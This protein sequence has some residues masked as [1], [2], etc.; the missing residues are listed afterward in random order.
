MIAARGGFTMR[1]TAIL[2]T[3]S[4]LAIVAPQPLRAQAA[5]APAPAK[6][7]AAAGD[8]SALIERAKRER[9]PDQPNFVQPIVRLAPYTVNLE[10]RVGSLNANAAVH[11]RDAELFLVIEGSGT[12]VTGGTLKNE[13]RTNADNLQGSAI[14]GGAS[15]RI[16]KGDWVLVP[17]RTPHWF[18]GIDGTL[19]LMSMHLPHTGAAAAGR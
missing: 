12:V 14:E 15:R 9:K 17:E 5:A 4:L 10:Y 18:T 1:L 13:Q 8:V 16:A 6:L 3:S 11:D 7:F 2:V 19:V